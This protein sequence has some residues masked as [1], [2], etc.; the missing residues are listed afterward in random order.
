M[1]DSIGM[2]I[3]VDPN[4]LRQQE[5]LLFTAETWSIVPGVARGHLPN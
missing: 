5:E 3:Y 1:Q 2:K 4:A